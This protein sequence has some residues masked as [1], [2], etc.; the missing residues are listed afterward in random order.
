MEN[1]Q[2]SVM[3]RGC[4][5][6]DGTH[7]IDCRA[8][9]RAAKEKLQ[10]EC[11][12]RPEYGVTQTTGVPLGPPCCG[13]CDLE[14]RPERESEFDTCRGEVDGGDTPAHERRVCQC[15]APMCTNYLCAV[16]GVAVPWHKNLMIANPTIAGR[17]CN[18]CVDVEAAYHGLDV[19]EMHACRARL[20]TKRIARSPHRT[21][22]NSAPPTADLSTNA[23]LL[24]PPQDARHRFEQEIARARGARPNAVSRPEGVLPRVLPACLLPERMSLVE[25]TRSGDSRSQSYLER[26]EACWCH[27]AKDCDGNHEFHNV[28]VHNVSMFSK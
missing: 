23:T 13:R 12:H 10:T 3:C 28:T 22:G 24:P 26:G 27:R 18:D 6:R 7:E 19:E 20:R 25:K 8:V 15:H 16:C 9:R 1:E 14:L 11:D 2:S 17:F 21:L 5:R 4:G